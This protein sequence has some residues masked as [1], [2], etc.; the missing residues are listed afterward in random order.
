MES[1]FPADFLLHIGNDPAA[2][3]V[4]G[5]IVGLIAGIH[6]PGNSVFFQPFLDFLPPG[7]QKRT[8]DL[9]PHRTDGA[10]SL[11]S[12]TADQMKQ[13][14]LRPV[15]PVV[16]NSDPVRAELLRGLLKRLIAHF[17][18]GFLQRHMPFSGLLFH[19]LF[20]QEKRYIPLR[21]QPA[22]ICGVLPRFLSD[23]VI[24]MNRSD[25][26]AA[27]LTQPHEQRKKTDRISAA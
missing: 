25:L 24:D 12:C 21:T 6:A 9:S 20:L 16:G 4:S 11:Q 2:D 27:F 15:V 26:P 13:Q 17:P 19:I 23:A 18:S 14:R 10:H 7:I 8:D 1:R 5:I 3:P 22:H